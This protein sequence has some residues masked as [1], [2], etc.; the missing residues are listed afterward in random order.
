MTDH[1][2]LQ[3]LLKERDHEDGR[4][5]RPNPDDLPRS[6]V[7]R[8]FTPEQLAAYKARLRGQYPQF[9]QDVPRSAYVPQE[10]PTAVTDE[11]HQQPERDAADPAPRSADAHDTPGLDRVID[12]R[13]S[14]E[15]EHGDHR[16]HAQTL[17]REVF[18]QGGS[19]DE[20]AARYIPEDDVFKRALQDEP[21]TLTRYT[22][23]T[24]LIPED[25]SRALADAVKESA[26][27]QEEEFKREAEL[28]PDDLEEIRKER[29]NLVREFHAE[30]GEQILNAAE[31]ASAVTPPAPRRSPRTR[32]K[33]EARPATPQEQRRV[34][35]ATLKTPAGQQALRI[36]TRQ[37][38][39]RFNAWLVR[40][41]VWFRRSEWLKKH[42]TQ[43]W[44]YAPDA[45]NDRMLLVAPKKRARFA[46]YLITHP[47]A[48]APAVAATPDEQ[49]EQATRAAIFEQ[50]F[51]SARQ[52]TLRAVKATV[53]KAWVDARDVEWPLHHPNEST[54]AFLN[55]PLQKALSAWVQPW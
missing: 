30:Q 31:V 38:V 43:Q 37:Y 27:A 44:E 14:D 8:D 53:A 55:A 54:S 2:Q 17:T 10:E 47:T 7:S 24:P 19:E 45:L 5:P 51:L 52:F 28:N 3:R 4:A 49:A 32:G 13:D 34:T 50:H 21:V 22:D 39:E 36:L 29:A 41:G 15:A 33:R 1:Q 46:T 40:D 48:D 42:L 26:P 6:V 35:Q 16:E 23:A 12:D 9:G 20:R 11:T 25:R 18:L